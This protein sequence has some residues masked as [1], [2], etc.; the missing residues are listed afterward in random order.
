M[1]PRSLFYP[2]IALCAFCGS[3]ATGAW[4]DK[5]A[6][7]P[8]LTFWPSH[9][10]NTQ[11][12]YIWFATQDSLGRLLVASSGLSVFDGQE[13]VTHPAANAPTLRAIEP[14]PDGRLW[15]GALNEI[16]YF[17]EPTLGRFE[18]HSLLNRLP[19]AERQVSHIWSCARLGEAVYFVGERKLY[20]WD[21][22]NFQI[23]PYPGASRI[24]PLKLEGQLWM[25]H[26]ETGLYR[27]TEAG[28]TL[29]IPAAR[30]PPGTGIQALIRDAKGVLALGSDG[31]FRLDAPHLSVFP[32]ETNELIRAGVPSALARGS[33]GTLYVGTVR[34]GVL[35]LSSDGRL[36]RQITES[37]H[38]AAKAIINVQVFA[39]GTVWFC[40]PDG[41]F[42]LEPTGA[43][44]LHTSRNGLEAGAQDID[45]DSTHLYAINRSGVFRLQTEEEKEVRFVRDPLLG[46]GYS[47]LRFIPQ[48]LL[49]GRHGGADLYDGEHVRALYSVLAKGAY[50]IAPSL[51]PP[52]SQLISEGSSVLHLKPSPTET[53]FE[54]KRFG[55]IPDFGTSL[56]E[57]AN[58]TVSVGTYSQGVFLLDPV[59]DETKPLIDSATGQ[60]LKGAALV[61]RYREDL[62]VFAAGQIMRSSANGSPAQLLVSIPD[63]VPV[64]ADIFAR[65]DEAVLAFKRSGTPAS[66]PGSQGLG[67]L[68]IG[69]NGRATW[70]EL[71]VPAL[72][73]IG[74]VQVV[75]FFEE[76][77]RP[78]LW[79]GGTEGL[80]RLD[81]DAIRGVTPPP[82]PLIRLDT[83]QSQAVRPGRGT[84]FSF[85]EHRVAFR[86]FTGDPARAGEWQVQT[87]LGQNGAEWSPPIDRRA[88]DFTNLSEGTY[89]FEAR[90][91]NAAGQAGEPAVFTFRI[92]PPWFRSNTAYAGY[93][94]ALGLGVWLTIRRRERRSRERTAQ[95]ERLVQERTAELVK[96]NAA[97]DDFLAGVSH[98]IRNPMNGV[99]GIAESLPTAGLDPE[100]RRRF[101]LLR[102][103]ASHLGSLIEDLLDLS[104]MQAGTLEL[105]L[106]PFGLAEL[107]DSVV[108]MSAADSEKYRIPVE[109]AISPGVP[110]CLRGDPRRIRQILLNFVGN[111]L[112]FSGRGKVE[113][114]VWARSAGASDRGEIVFAVSDEGPGISTEEQVRLFRRFERGA[115]ARGVS[116][117]GLGLALCRGY[118]EKMG[119]R[120]W[121]ESEPGRGSCFY[122]SAPLEAA[123]EPEAPAET[124]AVI[125]GARQAALV[126]DD[127]EHNRV[128][129]A[130]LLA[131]FGYTAHVAG[132]GIA[133]L[134]LARRQ[135]FALVFLDYDLPGMSGVEIARALRALPGGTA[136]ARIFATTAFNS[137][138]KQRECLEA[139]MDAFLGKPVTRER[140]SQ[141]LT[142]TGA[143]AP[144]V[145]SPTA[146]SEGPAD[147]LANLRLLAMKKRTS[148]A[149]E[150][151][152][153]LGELDTELDQLDEA[154]CNHR[155][156]DA[157]HHAHRL[158]GR[159]SFIHE[160]KLERRFRRIEE[161]AT[162]DR[163]PETARLRGELIPLLADLRARL[164]SSAP[165]APPV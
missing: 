5:T 101:G 157:S 87:R 51:F 128:V 91:V 160:R 141:A 149:D 161:A 165:D 31:F 85:N 145:P 83:T 66:S 163:W 121:L 113:L 107:V 9:E 34:R 162:R 6:G 75:R 70:Q 152:L 114:T 136:R 53:G 67:R 93:A 68:R 164:A 124:P 39:D 94:A 140:L 137:P 23:W 125:D 4:R 122:F 40:T 24:F 45:A 56:A 38:P 158:C 92:R 59:K 102:D 71:D 3:V 129:M 116:G 142:A 48:G 151:A 49:L 20:R 115:A 155:A 17:T 143:G 47:T 104:K 13:W 123:P 120:V 60:P 89:R 54:T 14:G 18:Y 74:L 147:P 144:V 22:S 156:D 135:D 55:S 52:G 44:T 103:C 146:A 32:A 76:E 19:E 63:R 134:D 106:R 12:P 84:E 78:V 41:F 111:A 50:R 154:L 30:L 46:D 2:A 108:A 69:A 8:W 36:L 11:Y 159:C 33:D 1:R 42:R 88:Y 100:T 90:T 138:A 126:V 127:Q 148:F 58:G 131:Q 118:A 62:L 64:A 81:Y 57:T 119:G 73:S 21:G 43:V 61:A 65:R 28:P 153:Y 7:L 96:A 86:V 79:V 15:I 29:E 82:T 25:H 35:I 26:R 112:K 130:D 110:R 97:K 132:D 150:L 72:A 117:T 133:A 10:L 105:E 80:L 109:A 95:L 37:T 99:I 77:G 16:G 139:G 27:I 98:E